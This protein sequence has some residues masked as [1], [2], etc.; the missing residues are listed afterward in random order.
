MEKIP[1]RERLGFKITLSFLIIIILTAG[2]LLGIVYHQNYKLLVHNVGNNALKI[3]QVASEKIDVEEFKKLKTVDDMEKASYKKMQEDLNYIRNIGGAKYLHTIRVNENG[4]Y[5]YVVDS[6]VEQ[7][8]EIGEEAEFYSEY[9]YVMKG[10]PYIDDVIWIDQYGI[11]ISSQYPIKDEN[12]A[13]VGFVGVDYDVE[14]E[15]H[16]FH[17]MK[18]NII[19]MALGLLILTSILGVILL[20]K[21][22]KPIETIAKVANKVANYDLTVENI[23]IKSKDEIGQLA[24]AFNRM[25]ENLRQLINHITSTSENLGAFSQQVAASTQQSNSMA[26]QVAQTM[27]QLAKNAIEEATSIEQA[28]KTINE[29]AA[30]MQ[31]IAENAQTTNVAGK[32]AEEAG[33]NGKQAVDKSI[34]TMAQVQMFMKEAVG[35]TETLGKNSKEIGNIVQIIT[36]IAD[37]TNLLALN[38]AIEAARAGDSGRGF[39]VVAEE[40]RKLAEESSNAASQ[41]TKLIDNVQKGT[42]STA[43]LIK[44]GSKV[45]EEGSIAVMDTGRAFDE[46]HTAINQITTDIEEISAATGQMSTG[47][48]QIVTAMDNIANLTQEGATG[49]QQ[50][51][52][53]TQ[54]QMATIEEITSSAQNLAYMADD[55]QKQVYQFKL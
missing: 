37:Q 2:S 47:S 41:I 45:V 8:T 27:D 39:A 11:L 16:A 50:A 23:N 13:V 31:Q 46:I 49:T 24:E 54:E 15:Y 5:V 4:E 33:E 53:A 55:L 38:A 7:E 51:S 20:K 12:G 34:Q 40:V 25:V 48:E 3:A 30:S 52:A 44:K 17:K 26:D 6:D 42:G 35:S 22:T 10:N 28:T 36:S 43:D 18:Q 21:V 14:T 29:M 1:Y 19:I 32:N 9:E